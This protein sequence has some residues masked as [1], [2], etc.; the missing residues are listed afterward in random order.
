MNIEALQFLASPQG[1]EILDK[2]KDVSIKEIPSLVITL[3]KKEIP[4][5]AELATLLKLRKKA[6]GK[7]SKAEEMYF[8]STGLEQCSGEN[9]SR[10]IAD[11]FKKTG[12]IVTDLTGG[13]GGNS[14]FLAEHLKV[15][16]VEMDEVHLYCARQNAKVYGVDK[17]IEFIHGKAEENIG[18][19]TAFI[20]DPQRTREAKTKT[21][22]FHNSEPNIAELLP[23]IKEKT[24]NICI[25]ISPAFDYKEVSEI[26]GSAEIEIVSEDNNNKAA[27][28]WFGDLKTA[29]RRATILEERISF[30]SDDNIER[31]K[32]TEEIGSYLYIPNKAISKAG[33]VN[34]VATE[35]GLSKVSSK[36]DILT[37]KK[38][39]HYPEKVFR[40]FEI[41]DYD[42]F[43]IK[44]SKKILKKHK[45][46][47]SH[48]IAHH[49]IKGAETLR[50]KLKL[51]EGGD[52]TVIFMELLGKNHII[53]T[54]ACKN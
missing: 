4:F 5:V 20:I 24:E 52:Y 51:K 19:T 30:K 39:I 37:S 22:S 43:S 34:E 16:L 50:K 3:S 38:L 45:I 15:R 41:L 23:K 13:M 31:V 10:Y 35:Y 1:K 36:H 2:Y 44:N 12:S 7:F 6:Q 25:K 8:T 47:R 11:R 46:D 26:N 33:L 14:I 32:I 21:R 49:F 42:T 18:E 40:S 29:T 48:I 17:N 53:I 54:K 9:V 28:L 27:L